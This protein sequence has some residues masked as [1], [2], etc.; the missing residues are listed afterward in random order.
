MSPRPSPP[1]SGNYTLN[2]VSKGNVKTT[3]TSIW[4][5]TVSIGADSQ[6]V[7]G[8]KQL[9]L[10]LA[11]DNTGS[12][13][14]SNKMTQLKTAAKDLLKTLQDAAKKAD[15][16]KVAIIPFAT[17][18]NV[19]TGNMNATWIRWDEWDDANGSCSKSG[20]E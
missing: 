1:A 2:L 12:M 15:D 8:M 7:W 18:V 3:F 4:Q 17:D 20:L 19:G 14:S 13:A 10:A 16:I 5:P 11:L 9:E 6:V